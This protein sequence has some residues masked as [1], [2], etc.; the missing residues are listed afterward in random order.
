LR[1]YRLV[2]DK[3]AMFV[4][5]T[6]LPLG[7]E[8]VQGKRDVLTQDP[9]QQQWWKE[10]FDTALE[11]Q[12]VMHDAQDKWDGR[13]VGA[14][15]TEA[16]RAREELEDKQ[17]RKE[18]AKRARLDIELDKYRRQANEALDDD[19]DVEQTVMEDYFAAHG[20]ERGERPDPAVFDGMGL[21]ETD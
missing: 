7:H 10:Q 15:R 2:N 21:N 8:A 14:W 18:Q 5:G 3:V 9:E 6:S 13:A 16:K 1:T 11:H 19:P 17:E 12:R 20:R 4:D